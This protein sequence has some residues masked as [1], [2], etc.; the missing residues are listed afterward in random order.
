MLFTDQELDESDDEREN[1]SKSY[2]SMYL[3][4]LERQRLLLAEMNGLAEFDEEL[5]RK[6]LSLIDFEE[7]KIREEQSEEAAP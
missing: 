1:S 7:L 2:E 3:E 4:L 5:I 6:H